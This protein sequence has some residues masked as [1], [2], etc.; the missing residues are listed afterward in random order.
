MV[1]VGIPPF[2]MVNISAAMQARLTRGLRE[3]V[4]QL[5]LPN[6]LQDQKT[7]RRREKAGE[8]LTL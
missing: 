3:S 1:D 2:E 8:Q 5:P 4:C 7:V 6:P